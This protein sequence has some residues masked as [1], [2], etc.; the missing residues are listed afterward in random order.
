[1]HLHFMKH[2]RL[3]HWEL[4]SEG[5]VADVRVVADTAEWLIRFRCDD[6]SL[7]P[8]GETPSPNRPQAEPATPTT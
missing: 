1:M 5:R 4:S 2:V 8:I 6:K 7:A 3:K